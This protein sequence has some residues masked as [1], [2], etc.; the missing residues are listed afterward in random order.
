METKLDAFTVQYS[1]AQIFDYFVKVPPG[2]AGEFEMTKQLSFNEAFIEIEVI[3]NRIVFNPGIEKFLSEH[4]NHYEVYSV[5][6]SGSSKEKLK[7]ITSF[8]KSRCMPL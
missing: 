8:L 7:Y 2:I 3:N 4:V 6:G 5:F 1:D